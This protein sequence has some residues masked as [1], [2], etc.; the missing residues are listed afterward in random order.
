ML[1]RNAAAEPASE[2]SMRYVD[3]LES[4]LGD[5]GCPVL[6]DA[7]VGH[8]PPQMTLINGAS[9]RIEYQ[10]GRV[11]VTQRSLAAVGEFSR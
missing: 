9:A 7:D 3:A 4:T 8:Q 11:T 2:G 5:L 6:Y 1:G 10:D